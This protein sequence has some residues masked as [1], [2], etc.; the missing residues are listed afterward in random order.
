[1]GKKILITDDANFMRTMLAKIVEENGYEVVGTAENGEVAIQ[2]YKELKPDLVTMDITMPG[3]DGI[4]AT[5]GIMAVDPN[6][7]IV[8]CSAMGQKPMVLEAIEA[9]AKDFIVKPIKP[10][11][12]KETLAK[13]IG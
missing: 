13:L 11:K 3:M 2:K 5:K 6:A 12:V 8:V 4:E 10:E 1:M 7:K 9:G